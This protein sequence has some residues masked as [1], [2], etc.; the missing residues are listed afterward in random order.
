MEGSG[1]E[2]LWTTVYARNSLPKMI[3]GKAYTK[4]LRACLLAD[5]A[6]HLI[7]VDSREEPDDDIDINDDECIEQQE[8]LPCDLQEQTAQD[9]SNDREGEES[10]PVS[11]GS[12]FRH[13]RDRRV[14]CRHD[15]L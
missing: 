12:D 2:D 10:V 8:L 9:D 14:R 3:E 6:L 4:A 15:A 1:L 13:G 5:A 11:A 7:L